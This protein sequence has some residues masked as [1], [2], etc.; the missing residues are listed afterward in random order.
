MDIP[1]F[2]TETGVYPA[3]IT[4]APSDKNIEYL[5]VV[6]S[7]RDGGNYTYSYNV[8]PSQVGGILP[9]LFGE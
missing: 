1:V 8:K 2:S 6:T 9:M 5:V 3:T 7:V 4:Y